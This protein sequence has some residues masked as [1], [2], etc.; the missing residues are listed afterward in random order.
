MRLVL[1]VLMWLSLTS[2]LNAQTKDS[3]FYQ[4][5]DERLAAT[6]EHFTQHISDD[7]SITDTIEYVQRIFLHHLE[8]INLRTDLHRHRKPMYDYALSLRQ[9]K[10]KTILP[11]EL[12]L[13]YQNSFSNEIKGFDY[14][15]VCNIRKTTD[16]AQC[17][18]C[19][20]VY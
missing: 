20:E 12:L 19:G 7:P 9:K 4:R 10:L 14:C 2:V 1:M 13:K 5:V 18:N 11:L 16:K 15:R 8:T 6:M 17:G 3:S